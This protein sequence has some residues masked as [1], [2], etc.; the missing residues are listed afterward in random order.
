MKIPALGECFGIPRI[1][2]VLRKWALFMRLSC[3]VIFSMMLSTQLLVA[4]SGNAQDLNEINVSVGL[5]SGTLKNAF[6]QIERQTSFKFA[7][8]ESQIASARA[9][10]R[11]LN[12]FW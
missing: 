8:V 6:R 9:L 7:Y 10:F 3:L 11:L 5:S 1:T 2:I 12:R 4:R